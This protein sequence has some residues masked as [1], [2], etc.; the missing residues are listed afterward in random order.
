MSRS[1]EY[2]LAPKFCRD[3]LERSADDDRWPKHGHALALIEALVAVRHAQLIAQSS[4]RRS[5]SMVHRLRADHIIS[6][7]RGPSRCE[8]EALYELWS[9]H[10]NC[11]FAAAPR[12][13]PLMHFENVYAILPGADSKLSMTVFIVSGHIDSRPSDVENLRPACAWR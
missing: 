6:R 7:L 13:N 9:I 1:R 10:L 2:R 4:W 8:Q 12:A 11:H 5:L 3:L